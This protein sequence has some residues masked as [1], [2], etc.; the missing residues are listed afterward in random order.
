MSS[1]ACAGLLQVVA[2]ILTVDRRQPPKY[3]VCTIR[4]NCRIYTHAPVLAGA[5]QQL[6]D[7]AS[8]E[9]A[10]IFYKNSRRTV[11]VRCTRRCKFIARRSNRLETGYDKA[12]AGTFESRPEKRFK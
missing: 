10:K 2:R 5:A 8:L 4:N 11:R 12:Q 6:L 9:Q 1:R 3:L 7:I